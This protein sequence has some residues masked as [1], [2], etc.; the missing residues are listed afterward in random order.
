MQVELVVGLMCLVILT[1]MYG[2][3]RLAEMVFFY[4]V[5][6]AYASYVF[7]QREQSPMD[8]VEDLATLYVVYAAIGFVVTF[9]WHFFFTLSVKDKY[10]RLLTSEHFQ[11][12]VKR[13][14]RLSHKVLNADSCTPDSVAESE[15]LKIWMQEVSEGDTHTDRRK[16]FRLNAMCH[17]LEKSDIRHELF[18]YGPTMR[19]INWVDF[20]TNVALSQNCFVL[21][22]GFALYTPD[23]CQAAITEVVPPKI[24]TVKEVLIYV[25]LFWPVVLTWLV[26]YKLASKVASLA[27]TR[28]SKLYD[29]IAT[30]LFGEI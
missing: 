6:T 12:T 5:A 21:E 2:A 7:I 14:V 11:D 13:I 9:I 30:R 29:R 28:L 26:F 18:R 10:D 27:V 15:K 22:G 23:N 17:S 25:W 1:L 24:K 3:G 19:I 20:K 4:I 16:L 8:A